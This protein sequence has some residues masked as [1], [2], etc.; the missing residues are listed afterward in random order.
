MADKKISRVRAMGF[1]ADVL[2][3]FGTKGSDG[4]ASTELIA[5]RLG[6]SVNEAND[7]LQACA[8]FKITERQGGGWVI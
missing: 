8:A 2:G 6:I 5:D 3:T 7:F 1:Y 4:I